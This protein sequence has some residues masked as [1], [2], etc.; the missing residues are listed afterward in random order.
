MF[1]AGDYD[2]SLEALAGV[3]ASDRT[4]PEVSYWRARCYGKLA[5]AA[6]LRLYQ[7]DRS[8]YRVHQLMGDLDAAKGEDVT[9]IAEYRA[10]I[11]LKPSLPNL[12]YSLGHLLWKN[13]KVD[14]ARV[15]LEAELAINPH[16]AGALNDLGQTY[17][18]EHHPEKAL[19]YLN[20]A[21]TEGIK[22]PDIHRDL[23]TAYSELGDYKRADAEF[24]LA[25][26]SDHDGSIHFKLAKVYKALGEKDKAAHEFALAAAL[27]R[28]SHSRLEKQTERLVEI[29]K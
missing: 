26:S 2:A 4:S 16:H 25:L 5:T 27:N 14:E 1:E 8:S 20:R 29:E 24:N 6:Y 9:A 15:E 11:D 23:G 10:A 13:S 12:H 19:P 17:L 18:L 3:P 28:E 21:L 7:A 22:T